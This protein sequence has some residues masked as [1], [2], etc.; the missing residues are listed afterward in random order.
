M[1]ISWGWSKRV[2]CEG[3]EVYSA[4]ITHDVIHVKLKIYPIQQGILN[5]PYN[6]IFIVT[7]LFLDIIYLPFLLILM[8]SLNKSWK[9]IQRFDVFFKGFCANKETGGERLAGEEKQER[10]GGQEF[11]PDG[12][13]EN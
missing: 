8:F 13:I 12:C 2:T 6:I 11:N 7:R 5:W 4:E 3:L 1:F 10:S 9:Y